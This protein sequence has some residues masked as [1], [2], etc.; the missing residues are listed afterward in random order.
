MSAGI[1]RKQYEALSD[2]VGDL[3]VTFTTP[4]GSFNEKFCELCRVAINDLGGT[5]EPIQ[6]GSFVTRKAHYFRQL[7][8][9]LNITVTPGTSFRET[10]LKTAFALWNTGNNGTEPEAGASI[11]WRVY[12]YILNSVVAGKIEINAEGV[13]SRNAEGNLI[14]IN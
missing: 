3:G 4:S 10:F 9:E 8:E 11:D 6:G 5:F 2:F 14:Y 7:V 12:Q 13:P 1:L